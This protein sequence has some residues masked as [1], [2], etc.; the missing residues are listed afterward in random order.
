MY[1]RIAEEER[2]EYGEHAWICQ[3]LRTSGRLRSGLLLPKFEMIVNGQRSPEKPIHPIGKELALK[4]SKYTTYDKII[5]K[6]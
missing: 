1:Q 2:P 4:T 5:L 3:T 6:S